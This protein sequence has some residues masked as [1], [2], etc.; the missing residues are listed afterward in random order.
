MGNSTLKFFYY[1]EV[2]HLL[3]GA[4]ASPLYYA[5]RLCSFSTVPMTVDNDLALC[6][7]LGEKVGTWIKSLK[8]LCPSKCLIFLLSRGEI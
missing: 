8:G 3:P 4:P 6:E 2:C 7:K 1:R 5:W